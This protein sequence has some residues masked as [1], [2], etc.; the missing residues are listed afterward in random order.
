MNWLALQTRTNVAA[1]AMFGELVTIGITTGIHATFDEAYTRGQVG[2]LGMASSSPAL[3]VA[4]A[5]VP[6][7]PVGK[8]AVVRGIDYLV[9]THEPDGFGLSRLMLEKP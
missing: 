1:L 4:T 7:S 5:D 3:T 2:D 9:A 6:A 8:P